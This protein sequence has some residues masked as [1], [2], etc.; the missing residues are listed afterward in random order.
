MAYAEV[1]TP[2]SNDFYLGTVRGL[3]PLAHIPPAPVGPHMHRKA[4]VPQS[5]AMLSI[6]TASLVQAW[7]CSLWQ[8][9]G[10]VYGLAHVAERFSSRAALRALHPQTCVPG[11][12]TPWGVAIVRSKEVHLTYTSRTPHVLLACTSR[13]P[14][15]H[16]TE[17]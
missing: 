8:V 1:G 9:R 15:V 12:C 14:L 4:Y 16:L 7:L 5:M 13:A 3:P 17:P 6:C 10:E 2:L 11:L